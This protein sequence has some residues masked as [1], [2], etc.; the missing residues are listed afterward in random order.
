M[1][2]TWRSAKSQLGRLSTAGSE[3]AWQLAH[4]HAITE[5]AV[6]PKGGQRTIRFLARL[7]LATLA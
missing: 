2:V 1:L 3:P 6:R 4:T 7:C 5:L